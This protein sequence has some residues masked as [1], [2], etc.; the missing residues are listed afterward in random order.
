V[1]RSS[2]GSKHGE[3]N[4]VVWHIASDI[5]E[6][7]HAVGVILGH[8]SKQGTGGFGSTVVVLLAVVEVVERVVV[9]V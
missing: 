1:K 2:L 9:L 8:N 6:P 4:I 7:R 5:K 3:F